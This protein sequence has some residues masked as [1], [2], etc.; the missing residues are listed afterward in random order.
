MYGSPS[1]LLRNP[2]AC[3]G[4]FTLEPAYER[5]AHERYR[6]KIPCIVYI[7]AFVHALKVRFQIHLVYLLPIKLLSSEVMLSKSRVFNLKIQTFLQDPRRLHFFLCFVQVS[8]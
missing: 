7:N 8:F 5:M 6:T 3:K 4:A 1:E 2:L